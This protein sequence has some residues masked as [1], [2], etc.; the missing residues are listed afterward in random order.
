MEE[1]ICMCL[2]SAGIM[3]V[4]LDVILQVRNQGVTPALF[5]LP[6]PNLF[7]YDTALDRVT[8][9]DQ[10]PVANLCYGCGPSEELT[11]LCWQQWCV[12]TQSLLPVLSRLTATPVTNKKLGVPFQIQTL[13]RK[14]FSAYWA[15]KTLKIE[16]LEIR[17]DISTPSTPIAKKVSSFL[18][19]SPN[20][21]R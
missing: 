7:L 14:Q 12:Q 17:T 10:E 18:G 15:H 3:H 4:F 11:S 13:L 1:Y 6:F 5:V 2:D 16:T 8:Q 20:W 9:A 21:S 19:S